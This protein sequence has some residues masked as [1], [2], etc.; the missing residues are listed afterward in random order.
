M[1]THRI[2]IVVAGLW[3]SSSCFAAE[4]ETEALKQAA[5]DACV[6]DGQEIYGAAKTDSGQKKKTINN[7]QGYAFEMVVGERNK[8]RNC[9]AD[10]SGE[11]LFYK[12]SF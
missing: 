9:F 4:Q 2:V 8:R 12:G 6:A 3:L 7:K 11:T 1:I 10:K 5:H